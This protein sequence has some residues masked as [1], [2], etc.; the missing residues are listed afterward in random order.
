MKP[1]SITQ[2]RGT[3]SGA[4]LVLVIVAAVFTGCGK[5]EMAPYGPGGAW[6]E[7]MR[8]RITEKITDP[9]KATQLIEQVDRIEMVLTDLDNELRGYYKKMEALDEDYNSTREEWQKEFDSFNEYRAGAVDKL[10]D[11]TI[12]M[13]RIAGREDWEVISDMDE[14]L[15]ESW[16]RSLG[17]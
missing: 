3:V 4:V 6:V 1:G 17:S 7:D 11:I 12:E 14:T 5:K 10:I 9:D 8:S 13:R 15:Y 2:N 16:Q